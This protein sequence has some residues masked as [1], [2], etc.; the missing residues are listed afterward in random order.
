[1]N[2]KQPHGYRQ[3]LAVPKAKTVLALGVLSRLPAGVIPFAAL[4]A[5]TQQHGIGIA[6]LGRAALTITGVEVAAGLH[7]GVRDAGQ[8]Q[9]QFGIVDGRHGGH[10][11]AGALAG[12]FELLGLLGD[13]PGQRGCVE[14]SPG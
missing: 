7:E 4:I 5:F 14:V 11:D 10:P 9:G 1:M 2:D 3:T 8:H 13:G 6:G 12:G